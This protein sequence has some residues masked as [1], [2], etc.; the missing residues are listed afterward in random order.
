MLLLFNQLGL[1]HCFFNWPQTSHTNV[2]HV[3]LKSY[4]WSG[5]PH[6]DCRWPS[7]E[8]DACGFL[9]PP[10]L[11]WS[12]WRRC[13]RCAGTAGTLEPAWTPLWRG[14]SQRYASWG[15]VFRDAGSTRGDLCWE[16]R[17][18]FERRSLWRKRYGA[19]TLSWLYRICVAYAGGVVMKYLLFLLQELCW[20]I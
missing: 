18:R 13:C 16:H 5:G 9:G 8:E 6:R 10:P 19:L 12:S 7:G 1:F 3:W 14:G 11:E 20:L 2:H 15:D 4:R 17:G